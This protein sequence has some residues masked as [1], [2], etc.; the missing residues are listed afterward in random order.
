[1]SFVDAQVGR[2]LD[3]LEK[4]GV[5]DNTIIVLWGDHGW[6]LG[7]HGFWCKHTNFEVASRTPLLVVAP[8]V[9]GGR[10]SR[11]L[12]EYIDI[13]PTL[14]DLAGLP[15]PG[16]LQ[17]RS[18]RALLADVDAEHKDAVVTRHGGGDAVRTDGYR[19][20]EMRTNNGAGQLRGVGLFDL[21]KDPDENRNVA[22][23]PTYAEA[24]DRLKG[25][26]D[27]TRETWKTDFR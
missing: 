16:H 2:L 22:E 27:A 20:M 10:V 17:G 14:C 8:G 6:Q 23:Y 24:R 11:R 9:E 4:L 3:E 12:V 5:A 7:E 25:I 19:Y 1:V 13:Y 18:L 26:L 15:K 21:D